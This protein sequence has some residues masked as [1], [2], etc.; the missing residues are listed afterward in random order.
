MFG[1]SRARTDHLAVLRHRANCERM[2]I[3]SGDLKIRF[4]LSSEVFEASNYSGS[5]VVPDLEL[6]QVP[7]FTWTKIHKADGA[8]GSY[9][10]ALPRIS[11]STYT[12]AYRVCFHR[13]CGHRGTSPVKLTSHFPEAKTPTTLAFD[14]RLTV[15]AARRRSFKAWTAMLHRV[16]VAGTP[17]RPNRASSPGLVS[18]LLRYH[19]LG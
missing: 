18:W 2:R 13:P 14:E 8:S 11:S 1:P 7:G 16:A 6:T 17:P 3:V 4:L 15:C 9:R 10:Y 12:L 19:F 5:A